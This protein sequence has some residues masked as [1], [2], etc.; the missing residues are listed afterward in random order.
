VEAH[1]GDF[2]AESFVFMCSPTRDQSTR[3]RPE[4][5]VELEVV[6]GAMKTIS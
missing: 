5:G 3:C 1:E 6:V 4:V 2:L